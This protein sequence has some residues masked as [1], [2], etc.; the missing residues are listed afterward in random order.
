MCSSDLSGVQVFHG[1]FGFKTHCKLALVVRRDSDGIIRSYAH[2]GTGNYNPVTARFYTDISLLTARPDIAAAVQSVFNYLTAEA[3]ADYR[4]LLVAPVTM[5][6]SFVDLIHREAEHA[7][8]G[9]P[10]AIVAKMN[11]LLERSTIEALYAASQ[12][13]VQIDLI[14]RGMCSLQIGRAHV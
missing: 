4:P 11:G 1:I 8:A 6:Q 5:A 13:G 2:L 10:A 7:R 9:K 12:A 3:E 14:I